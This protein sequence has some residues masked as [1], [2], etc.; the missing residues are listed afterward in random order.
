MAAPIA[1]VL[2]RVLWRR[3]PAGWQ[4]E[5]FSAV[6]AP[7]LLAGLRGDAGRCLVFE[8]EGLGHQTVEVPRV[9]RAA[10]ASL[11]RVRRE[12]PVV[13][14][15]VLGWGIEPPEPAAGGSYSTLLHFELT[16]SLGRGLAATHSS[17]RSAA[18]SAFSVAEAGDR[19]RAASRRARS[20]LLLLPEFVAVAQWG[21]P[22]RSFKSWAFPLSD[23]DWKDLA[24]GLGDADEDGA[25][26]KPDPAAR[27]GPVTVVAEGGSEAACP[28][29]ER[30]R[31]SGRVEAVLDLDGLADRA[32]RLPCRHP[33]NLAEAFP[34]PLN[35][36]RHLGALNL[37]AAT[38][39][40]LMVL[41]GLAQERAYRRQEPRRAERIAS[42]DLDLASLRRNQ[43]EM[44]A[45]QAEDL[46]GEAAI[47]RDRAAAL[48][49]LAAVWP[50]PLTL[51]RLALGPQE[52]IRLTAV[53]NSPGFD[54]G[55]LAE[56]AAGAGLVTAPRDGSTFDAAKGEVGIHGVLGGRQP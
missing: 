49:A 8:P 55:A 33:A 10:F 38:I 36:D 2:G 17:T 42:L 24:F 47:P 34:R 39:V 51:T 5:P 35:L 52:A 54:A 44:A 19:G 40:V 53:V 14:S 41:L 3:G 56:L 16:P 4:R 26:A 12:F 37:V 11:E 15:D 43:A 45:L 30:L 23:R 7:G 46:T 25:P 21:G 28:F 31:Q 18:W 1:M 27:R 50:D 22:K 29:W 13:E 6:A 9:N 32:A 20:M 48:R